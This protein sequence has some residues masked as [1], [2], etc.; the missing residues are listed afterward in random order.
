[1][2]APKSLSL[3]LLATLIGCGGAQT[4]VQVTPH[5]EEAAVEAPPPVLVEASVQHAAMQL[6]LVGT[7]DPATRIV[8]GEQTIA[9]NGDGTFTLTDHEFTAP[10]PARWVENILTSLQ[11]PVLGLAC[12]P[13]R[14]GARRG[15]ATAAPTPTYAITSGETTSTFVTGCTARRVRPDALS[16][17]ASDVVGRIGRVTAAARRLETIR[18][19]AVGQPIPDASFSIV[20]TETDEAPDAPEGGRTFHRRISSVGDHFEFCTETESD[21]QATAEGACSPISNVFVTALAHRLRD[22][23]CASGQVAASCSAYDNLRLTLE[24]AVEWTEFALS[25]IGT[26]P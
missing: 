2:D 9:G 4:E 13:P 24:D 18:L 3:V 26:Q 10:V 6:P 25:D 11:A 16:N 7:I 23:G 15:G 21:P 1:M 17:A 8:M 22:A 5:R 12:P 19:D 14:G 20:T